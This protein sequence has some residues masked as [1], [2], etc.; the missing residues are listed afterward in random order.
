MEIA[1]RENQ[2]R[3]PTLPT[4][5]AAGSKFRGLRLPFLQLWLTATRS[6]FTSRAMTPV[7]DGKTGSAPKGTSSYTGGTGKFEG[8]KGKGTYKGKADA[9]GTV[10]SDIEGDYELP[11]KKSYTIAGAAPQRC[12]LAIFF[13]TDLIFRWFLRECDHH[14]CRKCSRQNLP[15][16]LLI[17]GGAGIMVTRGRRTS[18]EVVAGVDLGGTAINYTLSISKS[19]FSSRAC[20][21]IPPSPSRDQMSASSRSPT[22][23][24]SPPT[25]LAFCLRIS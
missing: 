4:V 8:I 10:S 24:R 11:D 18:V 6:T 1:G 13:P 9:S 15:Q 2:G 5:T 20:A 16:V 19:S 22:A 25:R 21:S 7:A 3:R 12:T 14:D 23:S 17:C